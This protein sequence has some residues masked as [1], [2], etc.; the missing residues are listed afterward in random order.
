VVLT[1]RAGFPGI[2][3]PPEIAQAPEGWC[4]AGSV[5]RAQNLGLLCEPLCGTFCLAHVLNKGVTTAVI[6][7]KILNA[8]A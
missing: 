3:Q 1:G 2:R 8:G 6:V 4:A 7:L 5:L